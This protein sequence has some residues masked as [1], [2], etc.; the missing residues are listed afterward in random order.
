MKENIHKYAYGGFGDHDFR[1]MVSFSYK[2][3]MF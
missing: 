2:N 3:L 1:R